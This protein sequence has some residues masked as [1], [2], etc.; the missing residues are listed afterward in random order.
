MADKYNVTSV[1]ANPAEDRAHRIRFYF[2]SMSLR[3]ACVA[4]LLWVRGWWVIL[5]V[6]GAVILPYLAVMVGNAVA[7]SNDDAKPEKVTP[8]EIMPPDHE[9][10]ES[11]HQLIVIDAPAE[12]RQ[13]GER[14][15]DSDT[16][17]GDQPA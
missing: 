15:P 1:G 2:I 3:F 11:P 7:N 13:T 14:I 4:S 5:P 9:S 16:S 8:A 17:A 10:S 6:L 12:R